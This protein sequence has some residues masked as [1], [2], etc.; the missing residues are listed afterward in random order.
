MTCTPTAAS[1]SAR[2]RLAGRHPSVRLSTP[3]GRGR[4]DI[5]RRIVNA[6]LGSEAERY[7]IYASVPRCSPHPYCSTFS[8]PEPGMPWDYRLVR[9]DTR[10]LLITI[11]GTSPT[12]VLAGGRSKN[13]SVS[14]WFRSPVVR[15][16]VLSALARVQATRAS[17]STPLPGHQVVHM[18]PVVNPEDIV[19]AV[20]VRTAEVGDSTFPT[21][22]RIW[23][24]D[25]KLDDGLIAERAHRNHD[26]LLGSTARLDEGLSAIDFGDSQSEVLR[27]L[28]DPELGNSLRTRGTVRLGAHASTIVQTLWTR[29]TTPTARTVGSLTYPITKPDDPACY[30]TTRPLSEALTEALSFDPV[31]RAIVDLSSLHTLTW[32]GSSPPSLDQ[33][34]DRRDD[35]L[36][37]DDLTS[38]HT[39]A[40][41]VASGC[42]ASQTATL[43]FLE[44]D[45][46]YH[47]YELTAVPMTLGDT[48]TTALTTLRKL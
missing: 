43:R 17:C 27:F 31:Y 6:R 36:H 32:L 23:S 8:C 39:L 30:R 35:A 2:R 1:S 29:D 10:W 37:D 7:R 5:G 34:T 28:S 14:A 3:T 15:L 38:A 4:S 40:A 46:S 18:D 19:V 22:P 41:Q 48:T 13:A 25:W 42:A 45:G 33:R 47:P 12:V 24:H 26:P 20:W 16:T 9:S 44:F 21:S 11:A